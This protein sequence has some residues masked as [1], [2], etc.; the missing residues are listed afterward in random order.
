[1]SSNIEA[2]IGIGKSRFRGGS[3]PLD[4]GELGVS[5]AVNLPPRVKE[6]WKKGRRKVRKLRGKEGK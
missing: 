5:G 2:N 1:M 3:R 6:V 4:L